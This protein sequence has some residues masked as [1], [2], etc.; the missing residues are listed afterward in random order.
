[1]RLPLL[2]T[3]GFLTALAFAA[4]VQADAD[5]VVS[6]D[7]SNLAGFDCVADSPIGGPPI[8]L[9]FEALPDDGPVFENDLIVYTPDCDVP[10]DGA[11]CRAW[12]DPDQG[13]Y[14]NEG[15]DCNVPSRTVD[16][17]AEI[18][19]EYLFEVG[20]GVDIGSCARDEAC[21]PDPTAVLDGGMHCHVSQDLPGAALCAEL[22]DTT[23]LFLL[24]Y[25]DPECGRG[26]ASWNFP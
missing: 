17:C 26:P 16:A 10:A 15:L 6:A 13:F 20:S 11:A 24:T 3:A 14:P 22:L 7:G 23:W 21:S 2:L 12:V 8:N 4:P 18:Q 19:D 5:C 9:C 25:T 1:M